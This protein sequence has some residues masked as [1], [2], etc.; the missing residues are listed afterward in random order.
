MSVFLESF[1]L[2]FASGLVKRTHAHGDGRWGIFEFANC[3]AKRFVVVVVVAG[4]LKSG[5]RKSTGV[6]FRYLLLFFY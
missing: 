3:N 5:K 1:S 4:G 6:K 2:I